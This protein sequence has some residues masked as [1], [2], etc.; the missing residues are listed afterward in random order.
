MSF[1]EKRKTNKLIAVLIVSL[2]ISYNPVTAFSSYPSSL[3]ASCGH[4]LYSQQNK[5]YKELHPF[6]ATGNLSEDL[7]E[8][9]NDNT[10]AA[11]V[12]K[13]KEPKN[14]EEEV[15]YLSCTHS[16]LQ[17]IYLKLKQCTHILLVF[18]FMNDLFQ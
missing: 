3:Q 6:Y 12:G 15:R 7:A 16:F 18:W 10:N 17:S 8:I 2:S 9:D 1:L 5:K 4:G 13:E 14:S 11:A